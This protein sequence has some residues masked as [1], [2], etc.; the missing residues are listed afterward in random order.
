MDKQITTSNELEKCVYE[1]F[2]EMKDEFSILINKEIL[3]AMNEISGPRGASKPKQFHSEEQQIGLQRKF[4]K[5]DSKIN[6]FLEKFK[7]KRLGIIESM[8]TFY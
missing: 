6:E 7:N 5:M 2:D 8:N 4:E 1:L 3:I